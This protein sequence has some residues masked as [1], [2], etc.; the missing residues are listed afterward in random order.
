MKRMII[1]LKFIVFFLSQVVGMLLCND[2][3]FSCT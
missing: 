2:V 3:F 1:P